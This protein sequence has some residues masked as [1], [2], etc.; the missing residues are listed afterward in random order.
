[1]QTLWSSLMV[2]VTTLLAEATEAAPEGATAALSAQL[3][4]APGTP[5]VQEQAAASANRERP[6]AERQAEG[7][8]HQP[9]L[10]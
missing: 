4:A 8:Q 7:G 5:N 6:L 9:A 2:Q 10:A 3:Q 1:M